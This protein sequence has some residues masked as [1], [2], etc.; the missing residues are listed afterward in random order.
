MNS[1]NSLPR[2]GGGAYQA[3]IA[4]RV[5]IG[6]H[7]KAESYSPYARPLKIQPPLGTGG[8]IGSFGNVVGIEETVSNTGLQIS[9]QKCNR[10]NSPLTSEK[11][12]SNGTK[13][14]V[15]S[16]GDQRLMPAAGGGVMFPSTER[17]FIREPE[18]PPVTGSR[19]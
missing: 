5:S 19:H 17:S 6:Q 1:N 3:T 11:E 12:S 7:P 18:D 8:S 16:V 14:R 10:D 9:L 13:K 2:G 4:H 15:S